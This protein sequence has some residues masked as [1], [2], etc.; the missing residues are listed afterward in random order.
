MLRFCN[1][2][3][4]NLTDSHIYKHYDRHNR[5]HSS[6][7][8]GEPAFPDSSHRFCCRVFRMKNGSIEKGSLRV[9]IP[10]V[11]LQPNLNL[12]TIRYALQN[13]V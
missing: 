11:L 7:N 6:G 8:D 4:K 5:C 1:K 9:P 10:T 2:K 3:K 12:P 13:V